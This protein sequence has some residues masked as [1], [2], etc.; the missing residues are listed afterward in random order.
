MAVDRD[1]EEFSFSR[2]ASKSGFSFYRVIPS[3]R[4]HLR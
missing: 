4:N 3:S 1:S 2:E